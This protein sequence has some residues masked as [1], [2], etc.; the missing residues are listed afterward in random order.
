[1]GFGIAAGYH[2]SESLPEAGLWALLK[3]EA[4]LRPVAVH[5]RGQ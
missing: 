5:W 1:M 2:F 4:P 3:R